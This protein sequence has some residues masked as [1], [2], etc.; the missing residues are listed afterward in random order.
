MSEFDLR[1]IAGH[2]GQTIK[3]QFYDENGAAID[4][5]A[6][7]TVRII[8]Y[9][10]GEPSNVLLDKEMTKQTS[11]VNEARYTLVA[12]DI[13]SDD[14][15]EQGPDEWFIRFELSKATGETYAVTP[16]HEGTAKVY[17]HVG[18]HTHS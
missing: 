5:L 11:P 6:Y 2:Y 3:A 18:T 7:D 17:A 4:L 9:E 14:V 12:G 10:A 1:L 15:T 8:I 16:D 13:T